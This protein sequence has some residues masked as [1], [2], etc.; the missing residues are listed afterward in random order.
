VADV[1]FLLSPAGAGVHAIGGIQYMLVL[2]ITTVADA[3]NV[4]GLL[5]V[6]RVHSVAGAYVVLAS[7]L[8]LAFIMNS[9][10]GET[11][12]QENAGRLKL[13]LD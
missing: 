7:M 9:V 10:N 3:Q 6:V 11:Y 2:R 8:L 12:T 4:A 13:P 1:H 5:T